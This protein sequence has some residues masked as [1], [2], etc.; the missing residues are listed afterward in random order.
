MRVYPI[1]KRPDDSVSL[2]ILS[3]SQDGSDHGFLESTFRHPSST[4]LQATD[5]SSARL[6]LGRRDDISVIVCNDDSRSMMWKKILN[7]VDDLVSPRPC[8]VVSSRLADDYLWSEVLSSGGWDVLAK[9]FDRI[10]VLRSV[11]SAWEHCRDLSRQPAAS[12]KLKVMT[13]AG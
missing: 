9:P 5:A 11:R 4:I 6:L 7:Y 2:T 10:E 1:S 12:L 13:A 8:L 3:V